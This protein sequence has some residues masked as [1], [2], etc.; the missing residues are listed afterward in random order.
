MD[1]LSRYAAEQ[2]RA[3]RQPAARQPAPSQNQSVQARFE[4]AVEE[5]SLPLRTHDASMRE[6]AEA[7]VSLRQDLKNDIADGVSREISALKSEI[8]SIRTIAE[9]QRFTDELRV[10]FNRLTDSIS[11]LGPIG[12]RDA[13]DLKSELD[14]LRAVMAGLAREESVQRMETRWQGLEARMH[15]MDAADLREDVVQLAYRIDDIKGQLGAMSDNPVIR[16]SN[17]S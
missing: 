10:D 6:I 15:E 7:L 11:Q 4:R 14:E 5:P 9:D 8:R 2:P 13:M 1:T 16:R 3:S 12:A 17:R